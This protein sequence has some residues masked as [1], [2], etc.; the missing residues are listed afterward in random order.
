MAWLVTELVGIFPRLGLEDAGAG[1]L[2]RICGHQDVDPSRKI[3]PGP[4]FPMLE[5]RSAALEGNRAR[6]RI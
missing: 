5:V 6:G 2:P 3:D 4:A 1:E